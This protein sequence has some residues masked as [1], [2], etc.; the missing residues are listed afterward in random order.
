MACPIFYEIFLESYSVL[1]QM[2]KVVLYGLHPLGGNC[3]A[4]PE[5]PLID[6]VELAAQR[7]HEFGADGRREIQA[8]THIIEYH[9]NEAFTMKE[10]KRCE[11]SGII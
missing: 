8:N 5:V 7:V 1:S 9:K 11:K 2:L 4:D 10:L 3:L 6:E